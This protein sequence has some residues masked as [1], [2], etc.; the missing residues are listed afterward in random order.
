MSLYVETIPNR[1]SPPAILLRESTCTRGKI[2]RRTVANLSRLPADV[3]DSIRLLLK[4]G[5]VVSGPSEALT[6]Q[7]SWPHGHVGA[8]LGLCRQLGLRRLLHRH[9]GRSRDLALAAIVARLIEPASKLATARALSPDSASTS[10]GPVL[11][12]GEV[13]GNELLSMCGWLS[14]RQRW[15]EQSLAHRHLKGRTLVLYDVSSSYLEGSRCPLAAFGYSRDRKK[16]KKQIT[17][18][19][20]C[21]PNGCPLA[22]EVFAGNTADPT[23]LSGQIDKV[24]ERFAMDQVAWVGDRGMI[25]SARIRADLKPAGLDWVS[26][27]KTGDIRKLVRTGKT[28]AAL[29]LETVEPDKVVEIRSPDYPGERLMVC[30]NPRVREER[31]RKREAL[32]QETEQ[33]LSALQASIRKKPGHWDHDRIVRRLGRDAN[34]FRMEKHFDLTVDGTTLQWSRKAQQIAQEARL[35]G[36]Y[37]IRTSLPQNTLA[38]DEAVAAYKSLSRVERAFRSIKTTMLQVRPV[39]VY[40]ENHV[41][42]HVFL[43]MLAYYLE[44]HLRQRLAPLL[45][46]DECPQADE[47]NS[48]VEKAE[49]SPDAKNKAN[50]KRTADGL[51]VHSLRTLLA[52][53][54]TLTLN[55]VTTSGQPDYPFTMLSTPTALQARA[56]ECLGVDPQKTC[57]M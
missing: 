53:L 44:W 37:V 18:G 30:L 29:D 40:T 8:L 26:A 31:A 33:L 32:L 38:T 55:E 22:I 34:R 6:V 52:H 48:P 25:T 39:Y 16:G 12:L 9:P 2:T 4:G 51:P 57:S 10:L 24:R 47:R 7:R 13:T 43:C 14:Q 17:Y 49:V 15:I 45:F 41:R 36:L 5:R 11:G 54:G 56:F 28:R 21:A 35:D 20:L 19:L 46:Q 27:L 1:N 42:G 23:T 50:S 3:V